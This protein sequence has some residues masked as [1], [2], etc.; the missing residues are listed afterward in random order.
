MLILL[1][2]ILL[3][4]VGFGLVQLISLPFGGLGVGR[5]VFFGFLLVVIVLGV[6]V[7]L[8]RRR[9]AIPGRARRRLVQGRGQAAAVLA[10]QRVVGPTSVKIAAVT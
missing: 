6:L 2:V 3:L 4:A 5:S 7:L 1:L 10:R 9:Q 8:G